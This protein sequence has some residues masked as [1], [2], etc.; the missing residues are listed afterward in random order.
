MN[1]VPTDIRYPAGISADNNIEINAGV[2]MGCHKISNLLPRIQN[3]LT[4]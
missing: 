4:A 1:V 3:S 2:D